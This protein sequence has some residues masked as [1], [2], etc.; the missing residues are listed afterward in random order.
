MLPK[1]LDFGRLILSKVEK[2]IKLIWGKSLEAMN[3][4]YAYKKLDFLA[5]SIHLNAKCWGLK[6]PKIAGRVLLQE[7]GPL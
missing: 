1:S 3:E 4:H 7:G 2:E 5:C 6:G